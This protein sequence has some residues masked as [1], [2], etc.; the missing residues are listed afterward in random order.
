MGKKDPRVDTYI[1]QSAPFAR[2]I[3]KHL[4]KIVHRGCPGVQ[5][6][7][8]WHFPHFDYNGILCGMAAFKEHCAFGFW[9]RQLIF[10][11]DG[12]EGKELV[13]WSRRI[14]SID[15][16]PD[17]E[18]LIGYVRRAA[19]LNKLGTRLPRT[20]RRGV[21]PVKVPDYFSAALRKNS[22]A[23]KTFEGLSPSGKREYIDWLIDAKRD[24]TR[25]RRLTTTVEWLSEGKPH[26]WRYMK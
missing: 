14:K 15:D 4:R 7:I 22:K 19:E 16:L 18:A 13:N 11:S 17:E 5:E 26:N 21:Q 23:R 20:E 3:L 6:T 24:E 10:G 1:R 25:Q 9:K 12:A 2:P 8:K